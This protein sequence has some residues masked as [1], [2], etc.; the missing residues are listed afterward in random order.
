MS[1]PKNTTNHWGPAPS[2][3]R[4]VRGLLAVMTALAGLLMI[5]PGA[6][7]ASVSAD[8]GT[9]ETPKLKVGFLHNLSVSAPSDE[10]LLPLKP[11]A[12][13][14]SEASAPAD[15][16]RGLGASQTIV[17]SDHWSYPAHGWRPFGPPWAQPE[18]YAAWVREFAQHYKGRGVFY[19]DIWNEPDFEIFWDGTREQFYET[20]A[21]AERVLREDL[22]SDARI[23]GPSTTMWR[24]DWIEGL[25]EFCLQRGCRFDAV[26]WHD[27]PD[28]MRSLP[29]LSERVESTRELLSRARYRSLGVREFHVNEIM[30]HHIQFKP[31]AAVGYF[32]ELER[33]RADVAIKSCWPDSRGLVNCEGQTLDGLLDWDTGQPRTLWYTWRAYADGRSS[34]VRAD[35]RDQRIAVLASRRSRHPGEAQLL[36]GNIGTAQRDASVRLCGLRALIAGRKPASSAALLVERHPDLGEAVVSPTL[37]SLVARLRVSRGGRCA[38]GRLPLPSEGGALVAYLQVR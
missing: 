24:L 1:V 32:S 23:V 38:V 33:A 37:D 18:R 8:F 10:L 31:G 21:I 27:L 26:S 5:S 15:R 22:G 4:G 12:W 20:F 34:R 36:L 16:V 3:P 13:R 19:W 2:S 9:R 29:R 35:S 11:T 14:S 28:D 30:G 25:A 17:L 7:A 6:Q